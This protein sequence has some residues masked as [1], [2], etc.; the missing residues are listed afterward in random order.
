MTQLR[1]TYFAFSSL[2]QKAQ[3]MIVV[4]TSEFFKEQ[5]RKS[6]GNICPLFL[7]L[8]QLF[9]LFNYRG[10]RSNCCS[11]TIWRLRND[12]FRNRI[13]CLISSDGVHIFSHLFLGGNIVGIL[14]YNIISTII[15]PH[16]IFTAL[17]SNSKHLFV[18]SNNLWWRHL[19]NTWKNDSFL[20]DI[21]TFARSFM[22]PSLFCVAQFHLAFTARIFVVFRSSFSW[23]VCRVHI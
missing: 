15:E 11:L 10:S 22:V 6:C 13:F 9:L 8:Q 23:F 1:R 16:R 19:I 3:A 18:Q 17:L 20:L 14:T 7:S 2:N 12:L 21:C 4:I 5:M